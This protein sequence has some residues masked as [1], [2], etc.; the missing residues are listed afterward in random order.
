[1]HKEKEALQKAIIRCHQVRQI[2][3]EKRTLDE[4]LE[5]RE[6][7]EK[8]NEKKMED[9]I[10][11]ING[12]ETNDDRA[13]DEFGAFAEMNGTAFPDLSNFIDEWTRNETQNFQNFEEKETNGNPDEMDIWKRSSIDE[14]TDDSNLM[15]PSTSKMLND[16]AKQFVESDQMRQIR[17]NKGNQQNHYR[18]TRKTHLKCEFQ[19]CNALIAC[20]TNP[21]NTLVHVNTHL[22]QMNYKC[23]ECGA[24]F[25]ALKSLKYH[26]KATHDGQ[27]TPIDLQSPEM[28]KEIGRIASEC[29]PEL[30]ALYEKWVIARMKRLGFWKDYH[31]LRRNFVDNHPKQR[32]RERNGLDDEINGESGDGSVFD[33]DGDESP[34]AMASTSDLSSLFGFNEEPRAL[35]NNKRHMQD[36]QEDLS[37]KKLKL[38]DQ[39]SP[40]PIDIFHFQNQLNDLQSNFVFATPKA[41]ARVRTAT[42]VNSRLICELCNR[43]Y[44]V[45]GNPYNTFRHIEYTHMD[46]KAYGCS[47]CD[48]QNPEKPRIEA[49]LKM[50]HNG[51]G[52]IVDQ[53]NPEF[54]LKVTELA[55]AC[56]PSLSDYFEVA[57]K[58]RIEKYMR[59]KAGDERPMRR[60]N[61]FSPKVASSQSDSSIDPNLQKLFAQDSEFDFGETSRD[62]NDFIS[63]QMEEFFCEICQNV[64]FFPKE[65]VCAAAAKHAAQHIKSKRYSCS[66]CSFLSRRKS[67]FHPH[68]REMHQG[69]AK[70]IDK[71]NPTLF[72]ELNN[73]AR[74]CFPELGKKLE[75][76]A[77][78]GTFHGKANQKDHSMRYARMDWEDSDDDEE[79]V[80]RVGQPLCQICEKRSLTSKPS[81]LFDHAISHCKEKRFQCTECPQSFSNFSD[82]DV[83]PHQNNTDN[84]TKRLSLKWLEK[85]M[86]CFSENKVS[87]KEFYDRKY[88]EENIMIMVG[89]FDE[90]GS[91]SSNDGEILP[92]VA[93]CENCSTEVNLLKGVS[94]FFSH[95]ATHL[96]TMQY[97]CSECDCSKT[98]KET[99]VNHIQSEHNGCG[100]PIDAIDD[101]E[102]LEETAKKCFPKYQNLIETTALRKRMRMGTNEDDQ[103]KAPMELCRVCGNSIRPST[104][105][106]LQVTEHGFLNHVRTHLEKKQYCCS[107]CGMEIALRT[108]CS[109]HV[110]SQHGKKGQVVDRMD[111]EFIDLLVN[112]SK[113]CFPM[114]AKLFD[115][116]K[117][118]ML[119]GFAGDQQMR[120]SQ[121][122]DSFEQMALRYEMENQM[123]Q[124]FIKQ[125][126]QDYEMSSGYTRSPS[127]SWPTP[128][129]PHPSQLHQM[130]HH[131]TNEES[132]VQ[133][134]PSEIETLRIQLKERNSEIRRLFLALDEAQKISAQKPNTEELEALKAQ[135]K[136]SQM[137]ENEQKREIDQLRNQKAK[138]YE[139]IGKNQEDLEASREEITRLQRLVEQPRS[140]RTHPV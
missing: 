111:E 59:A 91:R 77:A 81:I 27:G 99:M 133:Q 42:N 83:H 66:S 14:E 44:S 69:N 40:L 57:K 70:M 137:R 20:G 45:L 126:P 94:S 63:P 9:E 122:G 112:S 5:S 118:R 76:C 107:I 50:A 114:H 49:H 90:N 3:E 75:R 51:N 39:F 135:L 37:P 38:E 65:R 54:V 10:V 72:T 12:D 24:E 47:M 15:L 104:N 113:K 140:S 62:S 127:N 23:S 6:S 34:N 110:N 46:M 18:V 80:E 28:V 119:R 131:F 56:F 132:F 87:I 139:M 134:R 41:P 95:A 101:D 84:L 78:D 105:P 125:E 89:N 4:L 103:D 97:K 123:L 109:K 7:L 48:F 60:A 16:I 100:E 30:S 67:A 26:Q 115:N 92:G 120:N 58:N 73:T 8:I 82:F 68:I 79:M 93:K 124:G 13:I 85:A 86:E 116:F 61:P 25:R 98:D 52:T 117:E 22:T 121:D 74:K 11:E 96:L 21:Y 1:M 43:A 71:M 138:L 19:K 128:M 88:T 136:A 55:K 29:F 108:N 130:A 106:K 32:L 31:N 35:I 33:V 36:S 2:T 17:E 129:D 102:S 53:Q 64:F